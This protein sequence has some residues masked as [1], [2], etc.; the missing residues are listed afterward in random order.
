LF[1]AWGDDNIDLEFIGFAGFPA[2][3]APAEYKIVNAA[4]SV[5]VSSIPA[6]D[7][8]EAGISF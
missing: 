1:S 7:L 4:Q 2:D 8:Q 5:N 6:Q 3:S